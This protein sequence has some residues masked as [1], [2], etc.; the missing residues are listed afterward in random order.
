[1]TLPSGSVVVLDRHARVV[2]GGRALLGGH[3]TRLLRLTPRAQRLLTGR[4]LRVRDRARA[5]LADLLVATG[6]VDF[7]GRLSTA[8]LGGA[9]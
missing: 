2:D 5:V 4:V 8:A 6:R 3:P 1:M 7:R 9:A